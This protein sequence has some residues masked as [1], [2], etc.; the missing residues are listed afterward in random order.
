[1]T[2]DPSVY[3][4]HL[5]ADLREASATIVAAVKLG[6]FDEE[7]L[8]LAKRLKAHADRLD[9]PSNQQSLFGDDP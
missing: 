7:F 4:P 1:M 5:V 3:Q 9:P 6:S 8:D 2:F